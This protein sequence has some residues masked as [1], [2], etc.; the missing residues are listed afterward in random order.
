[1]YYI[2]T[3]FQGEKRASSNGAQ[4]CTLGAHTVHTFGK[5]PF[6][7]GNF[8]GGFR[9]GARCTANK[10]RYYSYILSCAPCTVVPTALGIPYFQRGLP[11]SVHRAC[12]ERAPPC[13]VA[14]V[15]L[16]PLK[17]STFVKAAGTRLSTNSSYRGRCHVLARL[18][19]NLESGLVTRVRF[20]LTCVQSIS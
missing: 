14:G 17:Y 16:L 13:T 1:M 11:K 10:I 19:L 18:C 6:K 12:T 5:P 8:K 15:P 20:C 4:R 7:I 9:N 2:S 3:I